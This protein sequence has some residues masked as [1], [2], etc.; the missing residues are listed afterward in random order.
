MNEILTTEEIIRRIELA[1]VEAQTMVAKA[2]L[3]DDINNEDVQYLFNTDSPED[4]LDP[5]GGT[6]IE[7]IREK[8]VFNASNGSF[9]IRTTIPENNK[10]Y[11]TAGSGGWST[12]IKGS[13]TYPTANVLSNCVGGASGRF[14]ENIVNARG[15]EGF[16]Y[17][18]FCCNAAG[19]ADRAAG[20]GLATGSTPRVGAIICWGGGSGGCGHVAT[21]ERINAD[22]SIYTFESGWGY[23]GYIWN[24][25][26]NNS[27]GRWG[28]NSNYY[29]RCFIYLPDDVQKWVDGTSPE[30]QPTPTDIYY[31]VNTSDGLWL[32]DGNGSKIKAYPYG[33]KVRYIQDGYD[34]YGYH[35][36]NVQVTTDGTTGYMAQVYLTQVGNPQ[37]QP[38]PAPSPET[39]IKGLDISTWQGGLDLNNVKNAGY[40]FCILRAGFTSQGDGVTRNKDNQFENFYKQ[41]KT[42]GMPIG[43]YW[44]SCANTYDKGAAEATYMYENCLKGRQFEYPI[45]I[46]VEDAWQSGNK[47]GVTDAIIGFCKTL[48]EKKFYAGVYASG[49]WFR[50]NIDVSRLGDYTKWL[51]VWNDTKPSYD[52]FTFDLWQNSNNGSVQGMRVDTNIAYKDF[53]TFIKE[54]GYNGYSTEPQPQPEPQKPEP[55]PEGL[56]VGDRVEIIGTGNGSA[57][58]TSNIAYGIGWKRQILKIYEGK[59]YP[60]MVGN[61]I[62]VTGFY[63]ASSL[64]KL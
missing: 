46:D 10:S 5:D 53:P 45:Y 30:P 36:L 23:S 11:I 9:R 17:K 35:Y 49:S 19:F 27:N 48:L 25:T 7:N 56:K 60:Y 22:G 12:C 26:R 58:G 39:G 44:Y 15:I 3:R 42:I 37:P 1:P 18:Q 13:P 2:F 62:G 51:A 40:Q 54:N 59:A 14:N 41:A 16:V 34:K 31:T 38:T 28:M 21:V 55:Q 64:R 43:A 6:V 24:S 61:E 20:M 47:A 33:T 32:L 50:N 8:E 57:Y 63:Q 52:T 29:F 4:M